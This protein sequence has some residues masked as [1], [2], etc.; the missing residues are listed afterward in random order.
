MRIKQK[1]LKNKT[2]EKCY[3]RNIN[4]KDVLVHVYKVPM[5][6]NIIA[7]IKGKDVRQCYPLTEEQYKV[8]MADSIEE[9]MQLI[10]KGGKI[11]K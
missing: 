10:A 9:Q 2:P 1:E 4:G 7:T 6:V 5:C 3:Y 11:W 8:Y